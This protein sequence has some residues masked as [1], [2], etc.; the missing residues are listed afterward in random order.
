MKLITILK[1][2]SIMAVMVAMLVTG[3]VLADDIANDIDHHRY[4]LGNHIHER[5]RLCNGWFFHQCG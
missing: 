2:A 4:R 1:R 3:V 5:W